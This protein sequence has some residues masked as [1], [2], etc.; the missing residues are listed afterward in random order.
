MFCVRL[1]GKLFFVSDFHS[2]KGAAMPLDM[3]AP[4]LS[5]STRAYRISVVFPL[6]TSFAPSMYSTSST[7]T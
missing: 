4:I 1:R 6:N 5:Y 2:K 7:Q 3:T